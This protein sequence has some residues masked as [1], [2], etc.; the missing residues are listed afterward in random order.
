MKYL[1]RAE[2]DTRDTYSPCGAMRNQRVRG[3][4]VSL[5][6]YTY[7]ITGYVHT[8]FTRVE[9]SWPSYQSIMHARR[10]NDR[11]DNGSSRGLVSKCLSPKNLLRIRGIRKS[12]L[13]TSG[14]EWHREQ[15]IFV[16]RTIKG[17]KQNDNRERK[18]IF[19]MSFLCEDKTDFSVREFLWENQGRIKNTEND[20]PS[21]NRNE[22]YITLKSWRI[23]RGQ[24]DC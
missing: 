7:C 19:R 21:E 2:F 23:K 14:F 24:L 13:F 11:E 9:L 1:G 15:P 4:H 8:R 6:K 12:T 20:D 5:L 16:F 22:K 18:A 17:G 3:V 10:M